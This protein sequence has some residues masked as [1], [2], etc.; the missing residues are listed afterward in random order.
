[1]AIYSHSTFISPL[2]PIPSEAAVAIGIPQ[3]PIL[4]DYLLDAIANGYTTATSHLELGAE[5]NGI[6]QFTIVREWFDAERANDWA[7]FTIMVMS[8]PREADSFVG[9]TVVNT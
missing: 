2:A 5:E 7:A 4:A 6:Q 1:M 8:D 9:C 3:H